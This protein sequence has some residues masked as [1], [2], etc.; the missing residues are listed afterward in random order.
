MAQGEFSMTNYKS[1]VVQLPHEFCVKP[2]AWVLNGFLADLCGL[3]RK[4]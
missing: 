2:M 1:T 3:E 4:R